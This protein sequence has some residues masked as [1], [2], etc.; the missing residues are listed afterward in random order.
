MDCKNTNLKYKSTGETV[1]EMQKL[2][3]QKKYYTGV[4]DGIFGTLTES[5]VKQYQKKNNLVV[6]GIFGP[7]TCQHIQNNT[8][9]NTSNT[10]GVYISTPHWTSSG[11]NKLG[12][13]TGY[14]CGPHSIRQNNAKQDIDNYTE[15]VIGGWAGTTSAGTGHDGLETAI[16]MLQIKTG[17]KI[18]VTWKNFSDLGS[19]TKES[20]KALGEI[21]QQKN[22][23]VILHGLYRNRYGH[24]E[25]LKE[26]NINNMTC[27]VLNSLG[28]RCGGSSYCGY[29][30]SRSLDVMRQYL[31]GISQKSVM[32][33][34]YE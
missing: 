19:T 15:Q 8:Q 11:C 28:N 16:R 1:K 10:S 27:K 12:Q 32:I 25:V 21:I 23:G 5:A 7:V 14:H 9:N 3:Q 30:E 34:T 33:L 26:I 13:C 24:Y 4:I 20:F 2:L 22:K 18:S 6:D 29:I 17:R 31:R